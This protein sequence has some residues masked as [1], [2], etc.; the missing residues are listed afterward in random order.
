MKHLLTLLILSSLALTSFAQGEM[1]FKNENHGKVKELVSKT[2]PAYIERGV[3]KGNT[4]STFGR[5]GN[6]IEFNKKGIKVYQIFD[7]GETRFPIDFKYTYK[8][9]RI[10]S[11]AFY[12]NSP[13]NTLW[14]TNYFK[15]DEKGKNIVELCTISASGDTLELT[16][17][18]YENNRLMTETY[19]NWKFPEDQYITENSY[20]SNSKLAN[21]RQYYTLRNGEKIFGSKCI[22]S[23]DKNGNELI[24]KMYDANDSLTSTTS[25]TY[26]Y[27]KKGNWVRKE[28]YLNEE[29]YKLTEREFNYY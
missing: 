7:D 15:Y 17:Y 25:N 4:N 10:I 29:I 18:R 1:H 24:S 16:T 26:F 19:R 27:D 5:N 23:Y 28:T 13:S 22:A 12:I 6:A 8:G 9:K 21:E 3:I 14:K 20:P 2:L 11:Q